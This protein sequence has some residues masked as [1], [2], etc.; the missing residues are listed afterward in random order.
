MKILTVTSSDIKP[1]A[2]QATYRLH[3]AL[4]VAGV[5]S[6]MLVQ[7]K[8][9]DDF[10]VIGPTTRIQK[11]IN[12]LRLNFDTLPVRQYKDRKKQL[13]SPNW[14][15]SSSIV[16]R[17]N[18]IN[19]DLVNL[20]WIHGGMMR[21]E[22]IAKIKAP[23]VWILHDMW[24]FTGG[25]H[26]NNEC[27]AYEKTCG[28][29]PV[30]NSK[31]L[32]DLSRKIWLRKKTT[33]S[34]I[35]NL[36]IVG[37]S[38]WMSDCAKQSS[39]LK[40]TPIFTIPNPI[41]TKAFAPIDKQQARELLNFPQDKKIILFGA[42][43]ATIDPRKG[44][45][46]LSEALTKINTVNTELMVFGGSKPKNPKNFKQK[47]NYL[48]TL[49]DNISLRL[50]YSAAD[51]MV[52]PSIQETFGQTNAE[53]MACSTPVVA[54]GATGQLDIVDHQ[55]NGYLAKPF[56]TNDLAQGIDWVLNAENYSELCQNSRDKILK[57]FDSRVVAK[58]YIALYEK[59]LLN[60]F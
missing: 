19:P 54:F 56:D 21:I 10:T 20:S 55:I 58:K 46:E 42:S 49:H 5:E 41:N 31:K 36:N 18:A 33:F 17:I 27:G 24:A 7:F 59:I 44:F 4:L 48:G 6:Q 14:V 9:S 8:F 25:C 47:V 16:N 38:S 51:V 39:L 53:S 30:L 34:K 3:K 1:G 22:D 60:K 37:L 11:M 35:K 12:K 2:P 57:E 23:I 40:E 13:F 15:P 43:S 50:L 28:T 45:K 52:V 29:C 26:Y 32:H